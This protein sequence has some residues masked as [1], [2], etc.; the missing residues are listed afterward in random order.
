[1]LATV[2]CFLLGAPSQTYLTQDA[3]VQIDVRGTLASIASRR[4]GKEYLP[5]GHSSPLLSLDVDGKLVSPASATFGKGGEIELEYPNGS[6]ATVKAIAARR[7]YRFTL[8]ALS[9][10]GNVDGVVWG[11]IRTSISKTIG[12]L[13]GVVRDGQWAIG[14]LGLDDNTIT[15]LPTDGDFAPM[16]YYVHSPDP[17]KLSVPKPYHEGQR[18]NIGGD[19]VSDVAF[20]SHPEEYFQQ[21]FGNG[22]VLEPS[23]GSTLA[24]HSRDRRKPRT[25][26]LSLL[27]GFEGS[28]PRHQVAD[29]VAGVDFIG[30]AVALYACPDRDGLEVIR[31]ITQ[32]EKLP[33]VQNNGGWVRDPA[34]FRADMAWW[35]PHDR[36]IEY[37]DALGIRAV[38]D[39]GQGEY[40]ANPN[41]LWQGPCVG[42]RDGRSLTYKQL[43]EEAN[44]HGIA[45]GLHTLCLFLQPNRCTDVS[46]DASP[47]LQ[48]VLRTTLASD[49]APDATEIV[50]TDPSYLAEDGTW[51]MRDGA[52]TLR[53]GTELI[54]YEGISSAAPWTMKGVQRGFA[55]TRPQP[56]RAGDEVAKLQ[57][58]C[59][60][61]FAPDMDGIFDYADYYAKAMTENGMRY[62]DFDGLESALYQGHGYFGVR[63]FLRR[64]VESYAKLNG[65]EQPRIMGSAV[66]AGGW[67]FM[68]TC[69]V[70]GGANMF[71]PVL[72]RWGIEGKD[73]RNGFANSYFA[74]TFGIQKY[75]SEWSMYDAENL[76]AK[77]IGW[78]ATYMLGLSEEAVERSGEKDAIFRTFRTWEDAR[79]AGAFP[80]SV[81][82]SLKDL[83]SKFH[84]ERWGKDGFLLERVKEFR[85]QGLTIDNS[86]AA[87][88]LEC[89]I[90]F[91]DP[92][93]EVA[94]TLPDGTN[95]HCDKA[96]EANGFLIVKG[97]HAYVADPYRKPTAELTL[98]RP[99]T[100]PAGRST[101]RVDLPGRNDARYE[102]TLWAKGKPTK[103]RGRGSRRN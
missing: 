44:R 52:N 82:E 81:K 54:H 95:L 56:H 34:T 19:G 96:I 58:N 10:R 70:G 69:N 25:H 60:N 43:T 20:Y 13:I 26:L 11:P 84:L 49:L 77:A 2:A 75:E 98:P 28:R 15:G 21:V 42:F 65:G 86:Y 45:Y 59:Y 64:F 66:F 41:D 27:P 55:G 16:G 33:Y 91:F 47:K 29:P 57:M 48:T 67:E 76:Q 79:V 35:G 4:T 50:V 88:P 36:M 83:G 87:Q 24:Y 73:I 51:P 17:Q 14:M 93:Q 63:R 18:F 38:Q 85:G 53:I 3:R 62:I 5:E 46:P 6:V 94:I 23:F 80:Q 61:G 100:L 40:Y 9:N 72:N 22:A 90:R 103:L 102:A 74:P 101:L 31:Q 7:Y 99:A 32:R 92:V 97:D 37:A 39:E 71:D 89:S 68:G 8:I 1:M 30:S 78:D 12:D